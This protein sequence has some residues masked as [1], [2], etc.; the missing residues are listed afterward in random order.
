MDTPTASGAS[1][2]QPKGLYLLFV[3]EMWERFSYY[4]MRA[5][6]VLYL[7]A[8]SFNAT[9]PDGSEVTF[10][11]GARSRARCRAST[12]TRSPASRCARCCW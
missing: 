8:G 9:L 6:L 10:T 5:L 7:I 12:T 2:A 1:L 3:V 4:G 11:T